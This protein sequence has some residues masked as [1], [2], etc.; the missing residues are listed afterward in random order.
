MVEPDTGT[1][2]TVA[3]DMNALLLNP[4]D[5]FNKAQ[6]SPFRKLVRYFEI[7]VR[8]EDHSAEDESTDGD[9]ANP[10]DPDIALPDDDDNDD[11]DNDLCRSTSG[12]KAPKPRKKPSGS[13]SPWARFLKMETF[14]LSTH[15]QQYLEHHGTDSR[16]FFD[17]RTVSPKQMLQYRGQDRF[18]AAFRFVRALR[19]QRIERTSRWFFVML[20]FFDLIKLIFLKASRVGKLIKGE[21]TEYFGSLV[22][23]MLSDT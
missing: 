2:L 7:A 18:V 10:E 13:R 21:I 19:S 22:K 9:T 20:M 14:S 5:I 11:D 23:V 16:S 15:I 12:D 8:K 6:R 1:T 17:D 4:K 3:Q